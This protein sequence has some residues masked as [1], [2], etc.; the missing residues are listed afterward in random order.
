MTNEN[1]LLLLSHRWM[2]LERSF[3]RRAALRYRLVSY[4]WRAK[5]QEGFS[6]TQALLGIKR[7]FVPQGEWPVVLKH[8]ERSEEGLVIVLWAL[9]STSEEICRVCDEIV[10]LSGAAQFT[11]VLLTDV[12]NFAYY[13][14]LGWLVEY[15]PSWTG[16]AAYHRE[17]KLGYLAW[18]Y[19]NARVVPLSAGASTLL[20]LVGAP[21][22][23]VS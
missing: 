13:A 8:A 2:L 22:A 19:R 16:P 4:G 17:Q 21:K 1:E 18:R 20:E 5:L 6:D 11:P 15:L 7:G 12:A 9:G 10:R 3:D 14:R 23:S